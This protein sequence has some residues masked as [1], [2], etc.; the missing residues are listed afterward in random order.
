MKSKEISF[1]VLKEKS[2]IFYLIQSLFVLNILMECESNL[3]LL[4]LIFRI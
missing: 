1:T 3:S 2:L 4:S